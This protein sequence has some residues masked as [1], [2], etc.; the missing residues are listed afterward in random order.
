[1]LRYDEDRLLARLE[2]LPPPFRAAFAAA[3]AER[4]LPAYAGFFARTGRGAPLSLADALER[5]WLDLEGDSMSTYELQKELS[6]ATALI[7]DE[8][9][10]DWVPGWAQAD[11]AAAAVAYAVRCRQGGQ[12]QDAAWAARRAYEALDHLL[13][14]REDIGLGDPSAAAQM[15]ANLGALAEV[16]WALAHPIVQAELARQR[17]DLDELLACPSVRDAPPLIV[18]LHRRAREEALVMFG[19]GPRL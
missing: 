18:A 6:R 12:A 13:R 17:R 4:L 15:P 5:L 11:D 16:E 3:C 14:H 1:M 8:D 10:D 2:R 7:T 9:E 19:R